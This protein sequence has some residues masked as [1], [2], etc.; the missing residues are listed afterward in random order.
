MT[1]LVYNSSKYVVVTIDHSQ[2]IMYMV[3]YFESYPSLSLPIE[4]Y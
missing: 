4:L 3:R 2:S 1:Y